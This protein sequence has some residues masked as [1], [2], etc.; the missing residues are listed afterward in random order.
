M[1]NIRKITKAMQMVAAAKMKRAVA[2]ALSSRL[3]AEY[4]WDILSS[5]SRNVENIEHP[6]FV[7]RET[8]RVLLVVITSN[9]GL[10]GAYNTQVSKQAVRF[11]ESIRRKFPSAEFEILTAGKKGERLFRR[12]SEK[13]A[14]SFL[15]LPDNVS[16]R[17]ILP[18]SRL[19][20][21]EYE[22]GTYDRAIVAYT[23][24]VSSLVQRPLIK[25]IAPI[26]KRELKEFLRTIGE[27]KNKIELQNGNGDQEE[28]GRPFA[29]KID[30]LFEGEQN[31]L[32]GSLAEKLLRMQI[33][34][35]FLESRASEQS[36]RMLAMKNATEAAGEM[37][38][39]FSLVF[40]KARQAGITREISEISAGMVSVNNL[41][42]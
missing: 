13:I 18:I 12:M 40:N 16:L 30:Y 22:K 23:D 1:G 9:R 33:Y 20:A 26:S 35:M 17:D 10:C 5:I 6:L 7:E 39:D 21:E 14:A 4:S 28:K 37:I 24:F 2:S 36:A 31:A 42:G 34:Q 3:Y 11:L 32:I 29:P 8:K 15:N 41:Q 38:E 25:Q 19:I 27:E